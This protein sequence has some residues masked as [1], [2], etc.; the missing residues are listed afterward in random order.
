MAQQAHDATRGPSARPVAIILAA[1]VARRLAPLT[2][3]TQKA[4]L[5]VRR[6]P[7]LPSMLD[8]LHAAGE[9]QAVI[10]GG[11]LVGEGIGF[12]KCGAEAGPDLVH[13]LERVIE[14]S[15]GLCEY[16]DAL[17]LFVSRHHVQAVDVT[18]LPWTEVDFAEDL[19]RAQSEVFPAIAR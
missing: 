2:D 10:P 12:F 8:A 6:R 16:E 17:H 11:D 13:L 1:G 18:G 5:P 19:R 7:L 14:E 15:H 4:L 9:R 3:Y